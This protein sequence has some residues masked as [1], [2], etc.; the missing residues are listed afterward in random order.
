MSKIAV[1]LGG[2]ETIPVIDFTGLTANNLALRK[3]TAI[4]MREAFEDFGF[5]YL[6]IIACLKAS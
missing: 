1:E 3:A 6:K 2:G 5:I 4:R